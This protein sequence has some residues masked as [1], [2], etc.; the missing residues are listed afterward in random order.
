MIAGMNLLFALAISAAGVWAEPATLLDYQVMAK[1]VTLKL[2]RPVGFRASATVNPP[3]VVLTL[4]DARIAPAVNEKSVA[5]AMVAGIAALPLTSADGDSARVIIKL[6]KRKDF[7]TTMNGNDIVVDL[8]DPTGAAPAAPPAAE[9]AAPAETP[10]VEK[11]VP[12]SVPAT[13]P[14]KAPA[15]KAVKW[16]VQV[17]VFSDQAKADELKK[18]LDSEETTVDVRKAEVGGKAM[19]R[20]LV[21]PSR[22]RAEAQALA[23]RLKELGH[24]GLLYKE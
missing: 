18:D 19:Y 6:A 14:A 15:K 8:I 16:L 3:A 21:G 17:G 9:K 12:E 4:E 10:V 7:T 13:T 5:S 20:V 22:S 1:Q 24:A 11:A 23:T 2:S